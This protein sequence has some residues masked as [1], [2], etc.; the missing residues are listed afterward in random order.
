MVDVKLRERVAQQIFAI[1]QEVFAQ[2]EFAEG[3]VGRILAI[4]ELSRPNTPTENVVERVDVEAALRSLIHGEFSSI[5]IEFN[6]HA[7]NYVRA[8]DPY[9]ANDPQEYGE[10]EDWPSPEDRDKA[11]RDNSV[12]T[13]QWYPNTPVGFCRVYASTLMGAIKFAIARA[14]IE[15]LGGGIADVH[16]SCRSGACAL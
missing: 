10:L 1:C 4:P 14:A 2:D 8:S 11:L 3:A 7:C 15:A 16:R 9:W 5:H 13:L 12:W 6:G